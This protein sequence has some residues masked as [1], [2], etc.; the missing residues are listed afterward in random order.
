MA[1]K[2]IWFGMGAGLLLVAL[3]LGGLAFFVSAG[4]EGVEIKAYARTLHG[5]NHD[6]RGTLQKIREA[7]DVN[8]NSIGILHDQLHL[9]KDTLHLVKKGN[10]ENPHF[11]KLHDLNHD[12]RE[13]WHEVKKARDR[14]QN[15]QLLDDQLQAMR[16]IL[17]AI[18]GE[19][20]YQNQ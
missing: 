6:M 3:V 20:V 10:E 7:H 9:M 2:V 18:K 12:M 11:R 8:G 17:H 13:V 5:L 14:E 16:E 4:T 1:K 19:P 15:L